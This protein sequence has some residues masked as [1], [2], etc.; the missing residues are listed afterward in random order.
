MKAYRRK[1][2]GS[3]ITEAGPALFLLLVIIFFPMLDFIEMGAAYI[4]SSIFHDYV[5]REL[6]VSAPPGVTDTAIQSKDQAIAK[7]KKNFQDSSF[8]NFLKMSPNDLSVD[9]VKYYDASGTEV[10]DTSK[11][12]VT[13][14]CKT[15][16]TIQP[17]ISIP[18]WG[19]C[20]GLNAPFPFI[21]S[22]QRPQEEKGR[23]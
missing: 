20:P 5:I 19:Q 10:T 18:W 1:C 3:A 21:Q 23:N 22:S 16:C 4:F 13:V 12:P 6:A 9:E 11:L 15:T 8:Y 17:F 2:R 14:Q 7:I